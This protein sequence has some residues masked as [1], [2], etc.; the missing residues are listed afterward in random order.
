MTISN[1]HV[2][3]GA[4]YLWYTLHLIRAPAWWIMFICSP[5][6]DFD[7]TVHHLVIYILIQCRLTTLLQ[8]CPLFH[9][10]T[11]K[12]RSTS[13]SHSLL[14]VLCFCF[15]GFEKKARRVSQREGY[16]VPFILLLECDFDISKFLC[17]KS[18]NVDTK[19]TCMFVRKLF[20]L[21][22]WHTS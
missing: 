20:S 14:L 11:W 7:P 2:R 22:H 12:W 18:S 9:L 10:G 4:Q 5:V 17:S 21:V 15:F 1:T 16:S 13:F 3:Q 6:T 8:P 19:L